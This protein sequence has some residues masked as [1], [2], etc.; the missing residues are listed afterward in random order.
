MTMTKFAHEFFAAERAAF[1]GREFAEFM[2]RL[3]A[4][5]I[6]EYLRIYGSCAQ[7]Q[8]LFFYMFRSASGSSQ[9]TFYRL[10]PV[11]IWD[12]VLNMGLQLSRQ[13]VG[14]KSQ[15]SQV[16][17]LPVPLNMGLWR[18]LVAQQLCKLKVTG[19]FPVGSTTLCLGIQSWE[20]T[21]L[22]PG[23]A[24]SDSEGRH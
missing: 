18:N 14:L 13:S 12:G 15:A 3:R 10:T 17:F 20:W 24:Q 6:T 23:V 16:R 21:R 9:P 19:S 2:S 11:R 5:V 7:T 22:K 8:E 4:Q 1:A